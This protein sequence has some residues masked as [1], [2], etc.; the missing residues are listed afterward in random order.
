MN[1]DNVVWSVLIVLFL[2]NE[3][4]SHSQGT[5]IIGSLILGYLFN[6]DNPDEDEDGNY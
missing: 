3:L 5:I 1:G 6:S 2:C 4:G